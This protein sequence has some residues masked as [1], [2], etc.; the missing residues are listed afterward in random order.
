MERESNVEKYLRKK[1]SKDS[2]F[3]LI[4][5]GFSLLGIIVCLIVSLIVFIYKLKNPSL[6]ETEI[7]IYSLS[8]Y[9]WAYLWFAVG[10]F[11]LRSR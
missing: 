1:R 2:L 4:K 11:Y 5:L 9:W 8:K 10:Y 6:T 7:F 3:T